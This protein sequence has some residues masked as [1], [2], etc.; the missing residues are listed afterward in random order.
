MHILYNYIAVYIMYIY[1]TNNQQYIEIYFAILHN[2]FK[3]SKY[4]YNFVLK[5][6]NDD[7]F[8]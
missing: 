2:R 8:E 5:R 4:S 1:M 7:R 3:S 6:Q